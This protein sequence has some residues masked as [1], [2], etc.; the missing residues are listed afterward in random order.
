MHGVALTASAAGLELSKATKAATGTFDVFLSHSV[1]DAQL[2]LGLK[3]L[4][5]GEGLTV[6]V[7]WIEDKD[8]DCKTVSLRPRHVCASA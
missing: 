5:E 1:R 3:K 7:D 6:Y 2:V 4:L 8:L